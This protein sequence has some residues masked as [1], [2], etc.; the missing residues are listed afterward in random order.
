[1]R[2]LSL[3]NRTQAGLVGQKLE[4]IKVAQLSENGGL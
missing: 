4:I 3:S 2:A 1:L